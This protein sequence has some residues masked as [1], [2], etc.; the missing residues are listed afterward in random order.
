MN[1]AR[2]PEARLRFPEWAEQER[3]AEMRVRIC[4]A[5]GDIKG[6]AHALADWIDAQAAMLVYLDIESGIEH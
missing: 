1:A 4:V 3:D 5:T 2:L 6:G